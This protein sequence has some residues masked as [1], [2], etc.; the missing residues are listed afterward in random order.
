MLFGHAL[1]TMIYVC[2]CLSYVNATFLNHS[3]EPTFVYD[4]VRHH[5]SQQLNYLN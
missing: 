2:L 1:H 4:H 3:Y 5:K